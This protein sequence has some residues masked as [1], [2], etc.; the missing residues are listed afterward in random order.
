M[1]SGFRRKHQ[2]SHPTR[3]SGQSIGCLPSL[4]AASLPEPERREFWVICQHRYQVCSTVRRPNCPSR[5]D[6]QIGVPTRAVGIL[7]RLVHEVD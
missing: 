3:K 6:E 7:D 5:A 1:S 4:L 2:P